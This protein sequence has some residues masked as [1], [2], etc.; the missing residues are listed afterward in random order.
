MYHF[1]PVRQGLFASGCLYKENEPHPRFLW[2]YDCGT[3]SS[4]VSL[5]EQFDYLHR[6]ARG[7]SEIDLLTISHFD[8][9]HISGVVRLLGK[10][11]VKT[12]MLPYVPLWKRLVIAFSDGTP[13]AGPPIDFYLDPVSYFREQGEIERI[14]VVLPGEGGDEAGDPLPILNGPKSDDWKLLFKG[15]R[16]K[17]FDGSGE[18]DDPLLGGDGVLPVRSGESMSVEGLWEFVPYNAPDEMASALFEA[19]VRDRR[20]ALLCSPS[21]ETRTKALETLRTLYDRRFGSRGKR[22]NVV[23]MFLYCGPIYDSWEET[24]LISG[25]KVQWS[26]YPHRYP[27]FHRIHPTA[28]GIFPGKC[29]LLYS[30]DGYLS[31][32]GELDDLS[33]IVGRKR[34]EKLGAFQVNHHG[35]KYNW[36]PG[37]TKALSPKFSVFC[38]Q[39]DRAPNHP[40]AEV[41]RDFW[42]FRPVQVDQVGFSL[43]GWMLNTE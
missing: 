35:S 1:H 28:P 9:D 3:V 24:K 33:R 16:F 4:F 41:L 32:A 23:S 37:V 38:S 10:F 8:K 31:K 26:D 43:Y 15:T 11:S 19:K 27:L 30:G 2:V 7:R 34:L 12:L 6:F 22:R 36:H 5:D 14:V 21:S 13:A 29:S 39:P 20:S 17:P 25:T 40:N 42:T 18:E